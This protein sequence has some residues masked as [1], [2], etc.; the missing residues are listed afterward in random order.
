MLIFNLLILSSF[1]QLDDRNEETQAW[2]Q[3]QQSRLNTKE[4]NQRITDKRF[5]SLLEL[6]YNMPLPFN[7]TVAY[8]Q[9]NRSAPI[10]GRLGD[11]RDFRIYDDEL[12]RKY[13][14]YTDD[15]FF[16]EEMDRD[17]GEFVTTKLKI[18]ANQVSA[19]EGAVLTPGSL[20]SGPDL[21][22]RWE[23]VA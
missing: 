16:H 13:L 14:G 12:M 2:L 1:T 10:S 11:G 15:D 6:F 9:H 4:L 17:I 19:S 5:K 3:Y 20:V 21:R 23:I 18:Y 7:R 22:F 8:N